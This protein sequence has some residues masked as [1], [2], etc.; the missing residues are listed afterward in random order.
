MV[1][2]RVLS[3]LVL[4]SFCAYVLRSNLSLAPQAM[5]S[6]LG[7]TEVQWGWVMAAFP[8]G[9][10]LFQFPGGVFADRIGP[11]RA[12]A[13]IAVLWGLL[14]VAT[15][16][17]PGPGTASAGVI[18]ASLVAVRFLVGVVQ[19][20]IFPAINSAVQRWFPVGQWAFPTGLSSTGLTLG[21]AATAPVL[22]WLVIEFGWRVAFNVLAP[23]AF[24]VA[25]SWWWY[26][27][28]KPEQHA[29]VNAAE[30]ELIRAGKKP[31]V[32]AGEGPPAWLRVLK[33]R[34]VLLLTLSYG[35]MQFVFY[36]VFSWFF[37]Y[38]SSVRGFEPQTAG[39][40][41][42]S[43]WVAGGVGA[44]L[45]GWVCDRMCRRIGLRWGCRWPVLVGMVLSGLLLIGGTFTGHAQ[46]AVAMFVLCFFFN[47]VTEGGY[48][49]V[50]IAVGGE[51]AGAAGG[52]LNTGGNAMGVVNALLVPV[53]AGTLGWSVAM[54][55]GGVLA[56][57]GA[58]LMLWVR[59]DRPFDAAQG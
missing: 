22:T 2:W 57:L 11:R 58:M 17:V 56:L 8:L 38:L 43:Q 29:A 36:D 37:Y 42:S 49:S 26:G 31:S 13:L 25:A 9:Y 18:I 41:V 47:Q 6:D 21:Y 20:P 27:R 48:W 14:T 10:A 59:A 33:N 52:V 55:L 23:F 51:H 19:A 45:G 54:S 44:A 34:D 53:V 1:R 15:T 12:I 4:V 3:I 32:E 16:L 30:I 40:V 5:M 39:W 46:L 28:D 7:L 24:L 50:S 35:C